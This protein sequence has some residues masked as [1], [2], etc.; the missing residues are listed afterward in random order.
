MEYIEVNINGVSEEIAG[1]LTA[2]MSIFCLHTPGVFRYHEG[3]KF[4]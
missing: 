1:I 4:P 2:E 3:C